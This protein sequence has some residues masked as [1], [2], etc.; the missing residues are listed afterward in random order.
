MSLY[1]CHN[2]KTLKRDILESVHT[3]LCGKFRKKSFG[4]AECFVTFTDDKTRY[5]QIY[6]LPSSDKLADAFE[7]YILNMER[8]TGKYIKTV[9]SDNGAEYTGGKFKEEHRYL[10]FY[11]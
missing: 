2:Q 4:G 11:I 9:R 10:Y 8:A 6:F 7:N 1:I 3:D 5:A